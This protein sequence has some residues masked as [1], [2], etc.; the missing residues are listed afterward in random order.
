MQLGTN[1]PKVGS[2]N[3][4]VVLEAI[5]T[6]DGISRVQIAA[7]TRLTA[8]TVSV[9]VRRLL[10]EGLV[11]E[12]GSAPSRGGKRRT[13][14]RVDARAGFA[15]GVH[16]DP[17]EISCVLADLA[18][19]PV[20]RLRLPVR[21]EAGPE[22]VIRQMARAA[23]RILREAEVPDGKVLG[24]GLACPGPLDGQGVMVSPP[25]LPGWDQV[26]IKGL[27]REHTRFPVT[28]DNDATAAA[29]GERWAGIARSTPSF[30]YLYLGTGIGG[31][32]FLDNQVYRG[33]SLNAAEFGH[34]TVDPDGP[35]C[36]CG[37]RGC[38][39]AVCCPSAIEAAL[40]GTLTHA[41]ICA[42]AAA[43]EP[44]ERRVIERVAGRLAAAAVSVVNM[45]DIDLLVLGGPALGEVGEIYREVI[46]T[47]VS[48]RPL[49]RRLHAVQVR[50]SPIA[51]DAAAIGAASLV[52]HSTYAPRLGTL[53]SG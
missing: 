50:T 19:R 2:Y 45:L 4:A 41:A 40:G 16:F 28:V 6:S 46:A 47:A 17:Q 52:F 25:R 14:L 31:G 36:Y 18:G 3:R 44:A 37:N 51:A 48:S 32:M 22:A 30:V 29:I 21:P 38:V 23:R 26:P 53:L 43:G 15:V 9:I 10:E 1:L 12:A 39:E 20:T 8:Q 13:I 49:A 27:L 7:R 24:V 5:Q 42:R 34:I 11:V 35:E 33:R